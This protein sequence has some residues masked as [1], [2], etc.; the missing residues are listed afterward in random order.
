MRTLAFMIWMLHIVT[1][2]DVTTKLM[3]DSMSQLVGDDSYPE[4]WYNFQSLLLELVI[5]LRFFPLKVE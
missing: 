4:K 5:Y 2:E 3:Y 1:G